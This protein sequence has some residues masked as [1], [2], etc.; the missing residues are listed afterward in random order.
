MQMAN[1]IFL[2]HDS[3]LAC[4]AVVG[5]YTEAQVMAQP[6][7]YRAT[8][9]AT[10]LATV[11]GLVSASTLHSPADKALFLAQWP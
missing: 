9:D 3:W 10:T 2:T 1:P 6:A 4:D 7:A 11:R 5:G 8:L